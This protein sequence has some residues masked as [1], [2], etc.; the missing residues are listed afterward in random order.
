M[1]RCLYFKL[2]NYFIEMLS[3]NLPSIQRIPLTE[4][5]EV[6]NTTCIT[7][8]RNVWYSVHNILY[9]RYDTAKLTLLISNFTLQNML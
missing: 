5:N 8:V 7:H 2:T 9:S 4:Y 1:N 6:M 3:A